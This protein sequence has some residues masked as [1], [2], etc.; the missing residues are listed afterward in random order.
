MIKY[1]PDSLNTDNTSI[2]NCEKVIFLSK[3]CVQS[4]FSKGYFSIT[5]D[6]PR[7][8]RGPPR[9]TR[10]PPREAGEGLRGC[11]N[12]GPPLGRIKNQSLAKIVQNELACGFRRKT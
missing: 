2:R 9:E 10:D 8:T 1:H 4:E 7:E 6:P 11:K 12:E 3:V 5:M